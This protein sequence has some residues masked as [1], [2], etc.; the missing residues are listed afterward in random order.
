[1]KKFLSKFERR[2]LKAN[3]TPPS[4]WM[5]LSEPEVD[6][7]AQR[8]KLKVGNLWP[9]IDRVAFH[10]AV[11]AGMSNVELQKHFGLHPSTVAKYGAQVRK[12]LREEQQS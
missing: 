6:V 11:V 1:M 5:K 8:E 12:Q 9:K 2:W 4:L 10:E 3:S 7:R